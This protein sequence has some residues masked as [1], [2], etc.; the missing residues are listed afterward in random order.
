MKTKNLF[1]LILIPF[2]FFF[3]A[4]QKESEIARIEFRLTDAPGDYEEVNI[5]IKDIQAHPNELVDNNAAGWQSLENFKP[6]IYNLLT[7]RNG[8]DTLLGDIAWPSEKISQIRVILGPNNS[9]KV[10]GKV[11]KLLTPSAMQSGLKL[12]I[13]QIIE[14]GQNYKILLDFDA[15]RSIVE[16]G[17]GKYILRPVIKAISRSQTDEIGAIKGEI[18]PAKAGVTLLVMAEKDTVAG[19]IVN[20]GNGRFLIRNLPAKKYRLIINPKREFKPKEINN[21]Q[22]VPSGLKDLGVIKLEEK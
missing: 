14:N 5:D 15:A 7:L 6:G 8:L 10:N 13:N 3:F 11:E 19:A 20:Q 12:K 16:T 2:L 18:N 17:S 21:I 22:V 1:Y 4:C 9:I